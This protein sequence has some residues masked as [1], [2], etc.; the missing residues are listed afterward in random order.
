MRAVLTVEED[1]R[2]RTS[3]VVTG[4]PSQVNPLD[5]AVKIANLVKEGT[6]G[7]IADVRDEG[8]GPDERIV[9]V[10]KPDAITKVVLSDLYQHTQLEPGSAGNASG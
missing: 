10:L 9:L 6:V 2:G 7:G 4:L 3:L 5:L 8:S 1:S